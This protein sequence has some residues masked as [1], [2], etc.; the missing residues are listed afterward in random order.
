MSK[1]Q[2][3]ISVLNTLLF[4]MMVSS[5]TFTRLTCLCLH[6]NKIW[7]LWNLFNKCGRHSIIL[8]CMNSFIE[9]TQISVGAGEE[10]LGRDPTDFSCWLSGFVP[11][12]SNTDSL[13]RRP[14]VCY[15]TIWGWDLTIDCP[16]SRKLSFAV[17]GSD[18]VRTH[19]IHFWFDWQRVNNPPT[20]LH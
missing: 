16:S 8:S 10:R 2:T 11:R 17:N 18:L 9:P 1:H 6:F 12:W 3:V 15:L 13:G 19:E 7:C 20:V 5:A 14:K 4:C